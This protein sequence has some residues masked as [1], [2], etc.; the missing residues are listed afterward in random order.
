MTHKILTFFLAIITTI[1]FFSLTF[2]KN[3][4]G[5][6]HAADHGNYMYGYAFGH[7]SCHHQYGGNTYIHVMTNI[8]EYCPY[9]NSF[10]GDQFA[11][12]EMNGNMYNWARMN[13]SE[14]L[15][16]IGSGIWRGPFNEAATASAAQSGG[17]NC[18]TW[19]CQNYTVSIYVPNTCT[20]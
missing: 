4:S 16:P 13:C 5:I 17:I 14:D 10:N 2:S 6:A 20:P 18:N 11:A 7:F 15:Q 19:I 9:G 12:N 8:L 3:E 1:L